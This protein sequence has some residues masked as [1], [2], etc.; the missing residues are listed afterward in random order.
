MPY[1]EEA[2]RVLLANRIRS[3]LTMVG[4]VIGVAAVIAIQTLGAS[5][6]GAISGTLGNLAD[7]T[8]FVQPNPT[9]ANYQKAL[10]KQSDLTA[11]ATLPNVSAVVPLSGAS[12]LIRHEHRQA[13]YFITGD[14]ATPFNNADLAA[15]R[16]IDADDVERNAGVAVIT[17]KAYV[18][19]FPPGANAVGQSIY[20]GPHRYTVV[21]VLAPPKTG[22][23]NATF[24]GDVYAPY[25]TVVAQYLRGQKIAAARFVVSDTKQIDDTELAVIKKL[26]ELHGDPNLEYSSVDKSQITG[27]INGIFG[28]MTVVVA[29][30]AAISLLVAGIGVMNI[31]LVSVTERTREIGVRKAIGA[32]SGQVLAQ[33]FIEALVLCGAG[34]LTGMCIGL[35][36]GSFV[37][38][39]YIVK[40]TGYTAPLPWAQSLIV[41]IAFAVIATLA[42]GTYPAYRAAALDPIEALRYE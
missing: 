3:V 4:L 38:S 9:Q 15:G 28:A 2:L 11:L 36:A 34:C 12:D 30:I 39:F 20:V 21:G 42:F 24:G 26:R 19:L 31:M 17:N 40:L 14:A 35:A 8:F 6:S 27:S 5:M 22:L 29:I 25:T 23:L 32:R 10:L 37:N 41:T 1:I 13:R 7:N 33:F 18:K 16:R